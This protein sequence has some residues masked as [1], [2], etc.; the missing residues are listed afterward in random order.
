[1]IAS[2]SRYVLDSFAL[3]A[4]LGDEAGAARVR[5]VLKAASLGRAQVFV[6]A[7]NLGELVYITERE[8]GLVQAQMAL[9]AVE[10]LPIQILEATRE[11]VLAAAHIKASHASS[12]ADAFVVAAAQEMGATILTGDPEFRTVEGPVSVEWLAR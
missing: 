3:L 12:Y 8:R 4:H 1:M 9:N 11:R 2:A 5:A 7:I 10:Q 6:S